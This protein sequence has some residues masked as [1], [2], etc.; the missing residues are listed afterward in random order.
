MTEKNKFANGEIVADYQNRLHQIVS[1][2]GDYHEQ[3]LCNDLQ[4]GGR[5][6]LW[7]YD[8]QKVSK[9]MPFQERN[10]IMYY[11][12]AGSPGVRARIELIPSKCF[13]IKVDWNSTCQVVPITENVY[14]T[15]RPIHLTEGEL[16][17]KGFTWKGFWT[18]GYIN[19]YLTDSGLAVQL[20]NDRLKFLRTG[21]DNH[22]NVI[23]TVHELE[24]VYR[25]N[26]ALK[27][28]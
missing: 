11:K 23:R 7:Q 3:M 24:N 18:D 10:T 6:W 22:L 27:I 21:E 20:E 17:R 26:E 5:S 9:Y 8:P 4:T 1:I 2:P 13:V 25:Q 19:L 28:R 12:D 16:I 14:S 15:I